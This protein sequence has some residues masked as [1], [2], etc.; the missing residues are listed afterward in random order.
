MGV[1]YGFSADITMP[2]RAFACV[3][4]LIVSDSHIQTLRVHQHQ[5]PPHLPAHLHVGSPLTLLLQVAV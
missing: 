2:A 4:C 3:A 1:S 5:H